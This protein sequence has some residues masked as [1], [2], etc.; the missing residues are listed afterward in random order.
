VISRKHGNVL[1]PF[2]SKGDQVAPAAGWN[3][4]LSKAAPPAAVISFGLRRH[5]LQHFRLSMQQKR[6]TRTLYPLTNS[7]PI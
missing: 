7:A 1:G 5:V 2:K 6:P 3:A 4:L